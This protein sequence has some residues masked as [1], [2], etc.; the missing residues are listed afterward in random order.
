V[1]EAGLTYDVLVRS[2]ELPAALDLV[3][4]FPENSF[5]IDH[6]AK[7]CIREHEIEPWASRMAPLA[8]F[9]KVWVKLSGMIEEDD[10]ASWTADDLKPYVQ[11][12]LDW[13][14]PGRLIFGSNWPVCLLAGSYARVFDALVEALGDIP[15]RDRERI[16]G[17]N[18]LEAY[19]LDHRP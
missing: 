7:P 12:L 9:P 5:V 8:A 6:I 14:G 17:A 13:F 16:F 15:R 18:A 11:R 2:R 4:A 10:W 1:G 3:R 19:R